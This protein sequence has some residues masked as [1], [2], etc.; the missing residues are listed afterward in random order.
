MG[1]HKFEDQLKEK[2]SQR[3]I[4]PSAGSWEKLSGKLNAEGNQ[5]KPLIWWMGIAATLVG[6]I[7]I[8]GLVYNINYQPDAPV[9]VETPANIDS[10]DKIEPF[11]EQN[12]V[13]EEDSEKGSQQKDVQST[14]IKENIPQPVKQFHNKTLLAEVKNEDVQLGDDETI[15]HNEDKISQKLEEIIAEV[16]LKDGVAGNPTNDEIEALLYKAASEISVERRNISSSGT[17]DAG[18]LLFAVETELE[19]SFREKVF[20]LLKEGYLKARTAV[21]NR[22]Y[23]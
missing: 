12:Q 10:E 13:L 5:P 11:K 22:S 20:E 21:A 1:R 23:P 18:D 19:E 17:V 16:S 9:I 3:E 15:V 8:S 2:F 6:A 7:L 4:N 14:P